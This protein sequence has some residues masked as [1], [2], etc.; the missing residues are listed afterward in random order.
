MPDLPTLTVTTAQAQ[1]ITTA[2]GSS[3]AYRQWLRSRVIDYVIQDESIDRLAA[4]RA[5]LEAEIPPP[6]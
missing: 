1:R 5:A 3:L 4:D 2:F 6:T